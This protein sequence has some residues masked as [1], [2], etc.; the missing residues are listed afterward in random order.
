MNN[1]VK[2]GLT[3]VICLLIQGYVFTYIMRV[4]P[5]F[6]ISFAPLIIYIIYIYAKGK[7]SWYY[8]R[9]IYWIIAIILLTFL[10]MAA[11]A[12]AGR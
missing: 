3:T 9:P 4:E 8:D 2:V 7:K 11:Y 6:I 5:S 12:L 1:Q 10:D